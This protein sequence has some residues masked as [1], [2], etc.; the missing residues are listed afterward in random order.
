[1]DS[2]LLRSATSRDLRGSEFQTPPDQALGLRRSRFQQTTDAYDLV[3]DKV[4]TRQV[5]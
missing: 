5:S 3:G 1:L 2:G 4:I